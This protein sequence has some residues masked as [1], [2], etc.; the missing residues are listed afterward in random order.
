LE[1]DVKVNHPNA[2]YYFEVKNDTPRDP[3]IKG[4]GMTRGMGICLSISKARGI[5]PSFCPSTG[6]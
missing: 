2:K 5:K 4:M 1:T 3:I 6:S